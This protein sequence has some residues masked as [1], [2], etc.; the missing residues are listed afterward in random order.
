MTYGY[1]MD[2]Q[3]LRWFQQ[4]A[5]GATVTEVAE[6]EM[7]SQPAVSRALARLEDEVGAPLLERHGRVLR[8]THAGVAFKHHV[9]AVIHH[10]DDGLAAVQQ[11]VEPE[12]GVVTVRCQPSLGT[13]LVPDLVGSFRRVHPGISF[14]LKAKGDEFVHVTRARGDIDLELTT[15]RPPPSDYAWQQ[16]A[17]EPLRLLVPA[18]DPLAT[19]VRTDLAAV[20]D[21]RFVMMSPTSLL[22][23]QTDALCRAAGFTPEI[24]LVADDLP[25][26]RGYVAA[27]LGVAVVPAL[28]EGTGEPASGRV[29]YLAITDEGA[30]RDVGMVWARERQMLPAAELFRAHVIDRVRRGR[31]PSPVA[32]GEA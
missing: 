2:D 19:Q 14:D 6:L 10:L 8:M 29:R 18:D 12:T 4:V 7:V 15:L 26:V 9:D 24:A 23:A 16:V 31:L 3:V 32:V 5:D 17:T 13:W 11:L 1:G 28:W 21:A 22:S 30:T 27:G 25:T 20:A